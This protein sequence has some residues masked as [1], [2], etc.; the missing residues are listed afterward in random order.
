MTE[1][2]LRTRYF[3][4]IFGSKYKPLRYYLRIFGFNF[5][6]KALSKISINQ[7]NSEA[8]LNL[9]EKAGE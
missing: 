8:I 3:K 9:F 5:I 4:E 6:Y 7:E 2:Q 1:L